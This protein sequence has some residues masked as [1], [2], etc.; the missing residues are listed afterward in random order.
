MSRELLPLTVEEMVQLKKVLKKKR[1]T[2]KLAEVKKKL[3]S[4]LRLEK[5]NLRYFGSEELFGWERFEKR[6][7]IKRGNRLESLPVYVAFIIEFGEDVVN[8][9]EGKVVKDGSSYKLY[10]D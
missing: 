10:E 2:R 8:F 1:T 3:F 4:F 6:I 9:Y 5:T 7:Y